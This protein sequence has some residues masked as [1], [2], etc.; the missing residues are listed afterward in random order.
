MSA[1]GQGHPII[2]SHHERNGVKKLIKRMHGY[3]KF[4]CTHPPTHKVYAFQPT[5]GML[6]FDVYS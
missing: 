4:K 6:L 3:R 5:A 2:R 1:D